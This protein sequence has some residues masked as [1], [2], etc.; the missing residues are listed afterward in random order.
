MGLARKGT[1]A[2][3][4]E[5]RK[6]ADEIEQQI[7]L[8]RSVLDGLGAE[9]DQVAARELA[10]ELTAD[11][12][13]RAFDE[14]AAKEKRHRADLQRLPRLHAGLQDEIGRLEERLRH[15]RHA[16]AAAV[17]VAAEQDAAAQADQLTRSMRATLNHGRKLER[18]RATVAD[19]AAE[20][21]ELR[22]D[23]VDAPASV[24][25]PWLTLDEAAELLALLKAGPRAPVANAAR[26]SERAE[27]E[28]KR[29]R[30]AEISW[31]VNQCRELPLSAVL[32]RVP[33]ALRE[34]VEERVGE[35]RAEASAARER[36][37]EAAREQR[38]TG[39]L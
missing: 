33:E 38:R 26:E 18:L 1:G 27:R 5:A 6:R 13:K 2:L 31:A 14:L 15:E 28:A 16:E 30:E 3:L 22:P 7:A 20:E 25:E 29:S 12:S 19:V 11:G 39:L 35:M 32:P 24:D 17:R 21:C 36:D 8:S 23:D 34:E 4:D 9:R 37:R 10:G